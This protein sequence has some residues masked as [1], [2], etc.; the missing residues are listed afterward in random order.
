V[1]VTRKSL[2]ESDSLEI[3]TLEVRPASDRCGDVERQERHAMVL[4]V[5]GIF[6]RHDAPDRY[7]TG[8]A[9][10][11][12]LVAADTP[13]RISFPGA[14]GDRAL[15]LRAARWHLTK[16]KGAEATIERRRAC[17]RQTR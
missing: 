15:I 14:I 17:S 8:T 12:V 9:S 13:Y 3:S 2:F 1:N 10:H 11:A 7:I 16:S 5:G 6:S 4:P